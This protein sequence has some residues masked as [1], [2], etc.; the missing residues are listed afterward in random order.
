MQTDVALLVGGGEPAGPWPY[1]GTGPRTE[2]ASRA[3]LLLAG[4][5]TTGARELAAQVV[6]AGQ[7]AKIADLLAQV[8]S[9]LVLA[10]AADAEGRAL[11]ASRALQRAVEV[12]QPQQLVRPFLITGSA[13]TP[14]LM[15]R[16][17]AGQAHPAAFLLDVLRRTSTGQAQAP[18]PAPLAEPLT[19]RE[20]AM[21]A[22]LPTMKS[23]VEIAAEYFVSVNTVKAHLKGL[24][25]KLD[26]DSRRAAVQRARDLHLLP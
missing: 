8:D 3:R 18:E 14:A 10:L 24:Y 25:R 1:P 26:V 12:A 20:L 5:E 6:D 21:L 2:A 13:R 15:R 4:G 11:D 9:L 7:G 22:E 16:L 19:A 17:A 23:N